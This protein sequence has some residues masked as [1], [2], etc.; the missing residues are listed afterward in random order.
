MRFNQKLTSKER[1]E[2]M[3]VL[4]SVLVV[5]VF[6]VLMQNFQVDRQEALAGAAVELN[7]NLPTYP[8][9]L[10]LLRDHCTPVVGDGN[11]DTICGPL[12][13]CVPIERD[14]TEGSYQ[15]QC[16]CCESP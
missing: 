7:R 8:G 4:S 5:A 14:C 15:N 1:K 3:I 12:K 11:C 2:V 16:L 9:A 6:G 13:T 10:I